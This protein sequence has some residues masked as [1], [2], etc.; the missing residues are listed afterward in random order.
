MD[1]FE[2][3]IK[4]LS[5]ENLTVIRG[6]YPTASF[7]TKNRVVRIPRYAFTDENI[8][9]LMSAHE[10]GHAM[11]TPDNWYHKVGKNKRLSDCVNI[12]EDIRIEKQIRGKYLGL[13]QTFVD[14]YKALIKTG[15]FGELTGRSFSYADRVNLF[16]KCGTS[17][18][19]KF[20]DMEYAAY[21][22]IS[23]SKT[24]EDVLVR[25]KFLYNLDKLIPKV[26]LSELGEFDLEMDPY[27]KTT[28]SDL[29]GDAESS[30][31]DGNI[32]ADDIKKALENAKS[33]SAGASTGAG[34]GQD[35]ERVQTQK[36]FD[37]NLKGNTAKLT[38]FKS[39]NS[40][41]NYKYDASDFSFK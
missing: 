30:E 20:S 22:Y 38:G 33:E 9:I 1:Y 24:F 3:Y 2:K 26:K 12:V 18:G 7:D 34:S 39:L 15:A 37:D 16:A 25:A 8:L 32:T 13:I 19:V 10:V 17:S 27:Q 23:N 5:Q 31:P 21:K 28:D 29:K 14:G 41:F 36:Y 6:N 11:F 40:E 35:D 4:L